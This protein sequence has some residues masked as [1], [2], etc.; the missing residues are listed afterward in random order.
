MACYTLVEINNDDVFIQRA[1]KVL[2]LPADGPLT[3]WDAEAVK[4]EAGVLKA[5]AETRRLAPNAVIRR[6]GNTLTVNTRV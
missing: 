2:G 6:V 4:I 5:M 1:R 3:T